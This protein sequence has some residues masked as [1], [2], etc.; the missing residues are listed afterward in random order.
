MRTVFQNRTITASDLPPDLDLRQSYWEGCDFSGLDLSAYDIRDMDII[1]CV[2]RGVRLPQDLRWM[3]SRNTNWSGAILP[4]TVPSTNHDLVIEVIKQGL[5]G[6]PLLARRIGRWA[7]TYLQGQYHRSWADSVYGVQQALGIDTQTLKLLT[8]Q[9]F[10]GQE[11]LIARLREHVERGEIGPLGALAP[12]TRFV[13][14]LRKGDEDADLGHLLTGYDRYAAARRIEDWFAPQGEEVFC[15]VQVIQPPE[16]RALKVVAKER[17]L[18]P[19]GET[20]PP[21]GWWRQL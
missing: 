20:T 9:L 6:K 2:A 18:L 14:L 12:R 7:V 8:E 21:F 4:P 1:N 15:H 19:P 17:L 11:R 5:G 3:Q 13:C 16:M 10:A